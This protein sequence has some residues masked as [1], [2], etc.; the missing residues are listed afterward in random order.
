MNK[1]YDVVIVG[2]G[3][4]GACV[5]LSLPKNL[6]VALLERHNDILKESS[7]VNQN[8]IH[9]GFHYPR[10]WETALESLDGMDAFMK[11]FGKH[12][13]QIEGYYGI[14]RDGSLTSPEDFLKFSQ[15]LKSHRKVPFEQ[16][17]LDKWFLQKDYLSLLLQTHEP[18]I[19]MESVREDLRQ[20]II[21]RENIDLCLQTSAM[22]LLSERPFQIQTNKEVFESDFVVNASFGN[23]CWHKHPKTPKVEM[24]YVEMV[25]LESDR[26]LPGV[27]LMDGPGCFGILPI[28]FSQKRYWWY[29]VAFS[30]HSRVETQSGIR[31]RPPFFNNWP[32]MQEQGAQAF[33]FMNHLKFVKSH[34]TPRT[35]I[36]DARV[37]QT[38]ARPSVVSSLSPGFFQVLSGKLT[39]SMVIA[40]E[41][42][43]RIDAELQSK[44]VTYAEFGDSTHIKKIAS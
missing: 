4:F 40:Q 27:T 23:L 14:V 17:S 42:A 38:A 36:I 9:H 18:V 32:R 30:V 39:T 3:L 28:G 35:L 1:K 22:E 13:R 20:E 11:R 12:T 5:A 29:S 15:D 34:F 43:K 44:N 10:S 8:R 16:T 6:K 19:D 37:E 25:E 7:F 41:V 21:N 31:F 2:G 26:P 33:T 24:Q